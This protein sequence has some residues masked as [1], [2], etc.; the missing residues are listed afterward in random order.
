MGHVNTHSGSQ[1]ILLSVYVNSG[2]GIADHAQ[3]MCL[4]S[5]R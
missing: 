4:F 2:V 1:V 5:Y 3:E